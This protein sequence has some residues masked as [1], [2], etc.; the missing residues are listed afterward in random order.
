RM[1]HGR[2]GGRGPRGSPDPAASRRRRP[3]DLLR[4]RPP[5]PG[6]TGGR[7]VRR[8]VALPRPPAGCRA[9]QLLQALLLRRRPSGRHQRLLPARGPPRG[10]GGRPPRRAVP[11]DHP[12]H[13]RRHPQRAHQHAGGRLGG[14]AAGEPVP[15]G[16]RGARPTVSAAEAEPRGRRRGLPRLPPPWGRIV[17]ILVVLLIVEYLVL[18]QLA[19]ARNSLDT[20]GRVNVWYLLAGV[21]FEAAAVCAYA[22]LTRAVLPPNTTPS[23]FTLLRI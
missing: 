20:L 12:A 1:V 6:G 17:K 14:R 18:P 10:A 16:P 2:D 22:G 3:H 4:R 9:H 11:T 15:R 23:F 7:H 19:G 8:A 13:R 21:G 5:R